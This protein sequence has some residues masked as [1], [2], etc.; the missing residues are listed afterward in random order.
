MQHFLFVYFLYL[1]VD[2]NSAS[3]KKLVLLLGIATYF[4]ESL[5]GFIRHKI[6]ERTE[7]VNIGLLFFLPYL[8]ILPMHLMILIPKF[9]GITPSLLF[10]VLKMGAD[11]LAFKIYNNMYT[12]RTESQVTY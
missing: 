5:I 7:K 6:V 1:L 12:K 11:I 9:L 2:F 10:L 3:V 4:L 8:R